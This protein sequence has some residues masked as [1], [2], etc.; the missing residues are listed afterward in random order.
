ME[1]GGIKLDYLGHSGFV[2][3]N[4][5]GKR[6]AIDPYSVSDNVGKADI[7][8]ITHGHYDHCSIKDIEKMKKEGTIVVVSPDGQSKITKID[9]VQM[10]IIQLGDEM[11]FGNVKIEAVPAYNI[12]KEFHPKREGWLG[13]LIKIENVVIY[14][15]GDTDHIPEMSKL[16]GHGKEGNIFIALLPVSGEYVMDALEAAAAVAT[17]KPTIAIPMHYGAGVAGTI[18]DAEKFIEV[19]AKAGFNAQIL[20]KI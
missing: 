20:E 7:I 8:L 11:T 3:T 19:C 6:I 10:Q 1:I 5:G 18:K 14:H 12:E 17:I 9:G 15:A 16:T 13:Y 4:G 2:I